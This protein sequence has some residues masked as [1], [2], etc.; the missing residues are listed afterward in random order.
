MAKTFTKGALGF[1]M[2]GDSYL[3]YAVLYSPE[4]ASQTFLTAS[5]VIWSSGYLA[6]ASTDPV[7]SLIGFSLQAGSN[8]AAGSA[9]TKWI[10]C[11]AGLKV[12]GNFLGAAAADNTL[13][14]AD[15]G[16]T[17]DLTVLASNYW[18]I[19]DAGAAPGVIITSFA[20][21]Q[22]V[23]NNSETVA[24]AGDT[25][26]RITVEVLASVNDYLGAD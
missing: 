25:N 13:A 5:P 6:I 15:L 16:T 18:Y 2:P 11:Y 26:A 21:D 4:A 22:R 3:E 12:F 1:G 23:P 17:R 9:T 19:L 20:S 8:V 14:A 10:P 24:V 7:T